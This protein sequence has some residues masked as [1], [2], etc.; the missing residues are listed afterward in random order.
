MFNALGHMP[1]PTYTA[2]WPV[3]HMEFL[4]A[5]RSSTRDHNVLLRCGNR[6][7][8]VYRPQPPNIIQE[9]MSALLSCPHRTPPL[10]TATRVTR[11]FFGLR[12]PSTAGRIA[13]VR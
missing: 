10:R 13:P 4:S 8:T 9:S 12:L 7:V 6:I 2:A 11:D 1:A 3:R 5:Q